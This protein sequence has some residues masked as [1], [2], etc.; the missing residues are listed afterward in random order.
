MEVLNSRPGRAAAPTVGSG[1]PPSSDRADSDAVF[2]GGGEMGERMRAFDWSCTALGPVATWPQ[3]LRTCVRIVLTS[4]QPM[5]VWWGESLI[6]LYNDAYKAIV[7]GKH[8]EALGQPASVVWRG[9]WDQVRPPAGAAVG[10]EEGAHHRAP[11]LLL[12]RNR[13]PEETHLTFSY[14]PRP[15]EPGGNR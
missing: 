2:A 12:G 8:P 6:N 7:G 3:T 5:F 15:H 14:N 9:V 4:R 11:P 10:W 1:Q 13:H